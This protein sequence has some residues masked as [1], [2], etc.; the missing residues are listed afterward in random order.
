MGMSIDVEKGNEDRHPPPRTPPWPLFI[1]QTS[2]SSQ[3]KVGDDISLRKD[4]TSGSG[5]TS[6]SG[7]R[8]PPRRMVT[9][10]EQKYKQY[11]RAVAR[12]TRRLN[13]LTRWLDQDDDDKKSW[14]KKRDHQPEYFDGALVVTTELDGTAA[15]YPQATRSPF[16]DF[17]NTLETTLFDKGPKDILVL[18]QG[19]Q[20]ASL[21]YLGS[22]LEVD[23]QSFEQHINREAAIES[24]DPGTVSFDYPEIY[25]DGRNPGSQ[26]AMRLFKTDKRRASP[27]IFKIGSDIYAAQHRLTWVQ[28]R[29]STSSSDVHVLLL[30][31]LAQTKSENTRH[32]NKKPLSFAQYRYLQDPSD[33]TV[34]QSAC[35]LRQA[36]QRTLVDEPAYSNTETNTSQSLLRTGVLKAMITVLA[37]KWEHMVS[38]VQQ[39]MTESCSPLSSQ[40]EHVEGIIQRKHNFEKLHQT[41]TKQINSLYRIDGVHPDAGDIQRLNSVQETMASWAVQ[42]GKTSK[43]LLGQLQVVESIKTKDAA[44]RAKNLQLLAFVFLP[45]GTVTSFYGMN[46]ADLLD[47]PPPLWT[48]AVAAGFAVFLAALTALVY[49]SILFWARKRKD[50]RRG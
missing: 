25:W 46:T 39:R 43:T 2:M 31:D 15:T 11:I 18:S 38:E 20:A 22:R 9:H 35:D 16:S 5:S 21:V 1:A 40:V 13:T 27:Q 8:D 41:L 28:S 24:L 12:Q 34:L 19:M 37:N 10:D 3:T 45:I 49:H 42:L 32:L 6:P 7:F 17:A 36:L 50:R 4:L 23:P 48:F 30:D 47:D 33:D 44:T 29:T 14:I 26:A